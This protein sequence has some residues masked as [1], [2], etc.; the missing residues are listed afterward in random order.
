M[1]ALGVEPGP[2]VGA[3]LRAVAE[4]ALEGEI[5]TRDEALAWLTRTARPG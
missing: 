2:Q 4:A 3:W 1:G 5:A